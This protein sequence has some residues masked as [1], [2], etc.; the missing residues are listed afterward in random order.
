M[1]YSKRM[2]NKHK[3]RTFT[4]KK[5]SR[6]I[7]RATKK[8]GMWRR[9][10]NGLTSIGSTLKKT[11]VPGVARDKLLKQKILRNAL[12]LQALCNIVKIPPLFACFDKYKNEYVDVFTNSDRTLSQAEKNALEPLV[13]I[14]TNVLDDLKQLLDRK[15]ILGGE[16]VKMRMDTIDSIIRTG[17][18]AY[19]TSD[20]INDRL[21]NA[22]SD[23]NEKYIRRRNY[24]PA[25][26]I[27][28]FNRS[29]KS[30]EYH[31]LPAASKIGNAPLD[32]HN[33]DNREL[34]VEFTNVIER[35]IESAPSN[36]ISAAA[37]LSS[38]ASRSPPS[39]A[40]NSLANLE[41]PLLLHDRGDK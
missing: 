11:F 39:H 40:T 10:E 19:S 15:N 21:R 12:Y 13:E 24:K 34:P 27:I 20:T 18:R 6:K 33:Y 1:P 7:R 38:A 36:P 37:P 9:V 41:Q 14:Q 28:I 35:W 29:L 17:D 4:S 25:D 16:Y 2:H 22:L 23:D 32:L 26:Q 5:G 30:G 3:R 8:G 31:A